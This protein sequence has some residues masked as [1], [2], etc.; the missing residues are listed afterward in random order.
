[1]WRSIPLNPE[2]SL[3]CVTLL[4]PIR[5][6]VDEQMRKANAR[7]FF[8]I[9]IQFKVIGWFDLKRV[10]IQVLQLRFYFITVTVPEPLMFT[11]FTAGEPP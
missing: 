5:I 8:M 1:M 11:L 10:M 4:C 7:N 3:V 9:R 2:T 6:P